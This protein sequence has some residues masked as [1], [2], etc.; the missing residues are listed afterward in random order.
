[1][2]YLKVNR[3]CSSCGLELA[4]YRSDDAPPY[5]TI[6]IAGKLIA[7]FVFGLERLAAPPL[8]VHAA[9]WGPVI[10]ATCILLLRPVKGATIALMLRL[11]ID[12]SEHGPESGRA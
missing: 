8:W 11:G 1:M 6:V 9:L 10:T 2:R 4:S 3:H 12:G 5:F 7:P